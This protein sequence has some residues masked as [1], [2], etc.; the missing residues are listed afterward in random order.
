MSLAPSAPDTRFVIPALGAVYLV[1]GSTYLAMRIAVEVLP[2][3]MMACARFVLV[4]VVLLVFMKSRGAA[5]PT[6]KEWLLSAPVGILMFV[7]GNGTVAYAEKHISSGIAAVVCGTMPLCAAA[8]GPLF[9]EK[10]TPREWIGLTLGFAGVAV[11]GFGQELRAEPF[12]AAILL[13][14]PIAW[15]AGSMLARK[16]PLPRGLTSAATQMITGGVATGLVSLAIGE[17]A[18]TEIPLKVALAWV[19]L[20]IFGSLVAY[21]AYTYLLRATR[22]AVATSY[23]YVNPAIAVLIGT[24]FGGESIGPEVIVAVLLIVGATAMVVVGRTPTAP[25]S[26]AIRSSSPS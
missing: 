12:A 2:P 25:S 1:W 11:L 3:F 26:P 18:P 16:L 22:P 8:M 10:T 4:G 9:G 5:W 6:R 23:S 19:Y 24:L 15:A 13:V 17:R 7:L 21:S 14:A 20:C